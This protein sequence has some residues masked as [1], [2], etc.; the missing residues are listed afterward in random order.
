MEHQQ[1]G[2]ESQPSTWRRGKRA[3]QR[4]RG[5]AVMSLFAIGVVGMVTLAG[6]VVAAVKV[7]TGGSCVADDECFNRVH[8]EVP[9]VATADPGE[10]ITFRIR[11]SSGVELGPEPTSGPFSLVHPVAGPVRI[12]GAE[13][14]D[15]LA[16]TILD[17]EPVAHRECVTD[18]AKE[19]AAFVVVIVVVDRPTT[20]GVNHR[21]ANEHSEPS[22]RRTRMPYLLYGVCGKG[23]PE[24]VDSSVS[25]VFHNGSD[26]NPIPMFSPLQR[27]NRR[28][29]LRRSREN[30]Q[31]PRPD[32]DSNGAYQ[33]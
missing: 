6:P 21:R 19:V 12:R 27:G 30:P 14:G 8:P 32:S 3:D 29:S 4:A 28:R 23:H 5:A 15:T 24:H 13:R 33:Q 9:M 1:R 20:G 26:Q 7:G 10:L 25:E 2:H 22:D 11:N 18:R 17:V 31:N 16:V